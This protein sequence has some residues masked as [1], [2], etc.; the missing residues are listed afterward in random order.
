M[1][2]SLNNNEISIAGS[3]IAG[4]VSAL[5]LKKNGFNPVLYE[6]ASHCG[7]N[8]HGDLEGLESWNLHP[9]IVL[10]LRSL[11]IKPTFSYTPFNSFD[12]HIPGKK[13]INIESPE[14]FFNIVSRGDQSGDI[15]YELQR[16]AQDCNIKIYF[17]TKIDNVNA[18]IIATGSKNIK[19]LIRGAVFNTDLD[20]Q[21]HLELSR[22]IAPYG[23][24]YMII[25]DGKGTIAVAYKKKKYKHKDILKK[26]IKFVSDTIGVNILEYQ[27]FS[28]FGSFNYHKSKIDSSGRLYIG[29]AGGF[30]DY[31]FGFGI[32][33]AVESAVLAA[34][35]FQKN[36]SFDRL[37]KKRLRGYM[38]VAYRNRKFF[39]RLN[40]QHFYNI[41]KVISRSRTPVDLLRSRSRPGILDK[42]LNFI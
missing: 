14:P 7:K 8:R 28:S 20:N 37:W 12:V 4:L 40:D 25:L 33:Y 3:G 30:Q 29:E 16:Q 1:Q 35:S 19:A 23:Y 21:I 22:E 26:L 36:I 34:E 10:Y 39:E 24:G 32:Q 11:G 18:D 6:K 42:V 15:D 41:C 2:N 13:S 5:I 31:L 27:E 9:D 17:N 38:R